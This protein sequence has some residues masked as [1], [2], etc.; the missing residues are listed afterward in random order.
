MNAIEI[1]CMLFMSLKVCEFEILNLK[2]KKKTESSHNLS[3]MHTYIHDS[4]KVKV[5]VAKTMY[6]IVC[7]CFFNV[8]PLFKCC[9]RMGYDLKQFSSTYLH[10]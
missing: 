4:A 10:L 1:I 5:K 9:F 8:L 3:Y 6:S 7:M 2:K